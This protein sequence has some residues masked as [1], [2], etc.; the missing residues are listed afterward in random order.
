[1]AKKNIWRWPQPWQWPKGDNQ[2][3]KRTTKK[4][5]WHLQIATTRIIVMWRKREVMMYLI[6]VA[7]NT[8]AWKPTPITIVWRLKTTN[9]SVRHQCEEEHLEH[10]HETSKWR[11]TPMWRTPTKGQHQG[12]IKCNKAKEKITLNFG[13]STQNWKFLT[14]NLND[15]LKLKT[16]S[17]KLESKPSFSKK[18]FI[19]VLWTIKEPNV[20]LV[21][22]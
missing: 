15:N 1:M 13:L 3:H 7:Y 10:W 2:E 19:L 20:V 8:W 17:R 4:I 12:K 14:T 18:K 11:R 6:M 9:T 16:P 21:P 22:F 5:G